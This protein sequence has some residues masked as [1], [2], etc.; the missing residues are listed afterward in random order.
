MLRCRR[1]IAARD[2]GKKATLALEAYRGKYR[3]NYNLLA[4]LEL[5]DGGLVLRYGNLV[6]DVTHWHDDTFRARLRQ[7]RLAHE[8][9]W[10]LTFSVIDGAVA[11]LHIH[12]QHDVHADFM[13]EVPNTG[14]GPLQL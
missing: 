1:R 10:W 9:D 7:R 2:P 12:S 14:G 5:N 11:K 4:T 13:P 6:A 3:G 8:R